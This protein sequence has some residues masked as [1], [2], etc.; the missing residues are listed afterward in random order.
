MRDHHAP[1]LAHRLAVVSLRVVMG[2][3]LLS[4]SLGSPTLRAS[5]PVAGVEPGQVDPTFQTTALDSGDNVSC[6]LVL[7]DGRVV[8]AVNRGS[9]AGSFGRVIRLQPDGALD[10]SFVSPEFSAPEASGV[11]I[12]AL[13]TQGDRLLIAGVFNVVQDSFATFVGRLNPD[14]TWDLTFGTGKPFGPGPSATAFVIRS[15]VVRSD[16]RFYAGGGGATSIAR[17][18]SRGIHDSSFISP[19]GAFGSWGSEVL[20]LD[21]DDS[22]I[23]GGVFT[24]G[25]HPNY[26][27]G[28]ARL[29]PNGA[30]DG[31][32]RPSMSSPSSVFGLALTSDRKILFLSWGT[33][34]GWMARFNP[35]GRVDP[36]FTTPLELNPPPTKIA[37]Q[38]DGRILVASYQP[39]SWQPFSPTY[40]L[41]RLLPD[42]ALDEGFTSTAITD[43]LIE[44]L[45]VQG[46]HRALIAGP[47]EKVG[48]EPRPHLAALYIGEALPLAPSIIEEP[49]DQQITEGENFF[50]HA[51]ASG[52]PQT[53][54]WYHEG[55]PLTDDASASL[56]RL[57]AQRSDA[58]RYELVVSNAL[59]TAHSRTV[60]VRIDPLPAAPNLIVNPS[61]EELNHEYPPRPTDWLW[62]SPIELFSYPKE[63]PRNFLGEQEVLHGT[64]YAILHSYFSP[65]PF[66]SLPPRGAL[67]GRLRSSTAPGTRYE[68]TAWFSRTEASMLPNLGLRVILTNSV[69]ATLDLGTES[70]SNSLA[71]QGF[72][73]SFVPSAAYEGVILVAPRGPEPAD[74]AY[75]N[76][77]YLDN[78]SLR[79]TGPARPVLADLPTRVLAPWERWVVTNRVTETDLTEDALRFFLPSD[80]PAGTGLDPRL[81]LLTWQP[82]PLDSGTTQQIPVAAYYL[83]SPLPPVTNRLT[84]IV[85]EGVLVEAGQGWVRAGGSGRIP[86]TARLLA[87]PDTR[88]TN[89]S[90]VLSLP[91]TDLSNVRLTST[92]PTLAEPVVTDL[93]GRRHRLS[94]QTREGQALTGEVQLGDLTFDAPENAGSGHQPIHVSEIVAVGADGTTIPATLG[95]DGRVG[96]VGRQPLLVAA[97][98]VARRT[99]E[100]YGLPGSRYRIEQATNLA[101]GIE[102]RPVQEVTADSF[103]QVVEGVDASAPAL[104][105]RAVEIP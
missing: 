7:A 71:W 18:T 78:L 80:A 34:Y 13:A 67:L 21:Q 5:P 39:V 46:T 64:N 86:L 16:Q 8:V 47:F 30:L 31:K 35:D 24:Y 50:L 103:P 4:A 52:L 59:G 44:H 14:G 11:G 6:L 101:N 22:L 40:H 79:A 38:A 58:G 54:R 43:D 83:G 82:R 65:R 2:L 53:F 95:L 12:T 26:L 85:Q 90:F 97:G 94:V 62:D 63:V 70:K 72:R 41:L 28:L 55:L 99:L 93:G 81:G 27:H 25:A 60:T 3:G 75:F 37:L 20:L 48:D 91:A 1:D 32:F 56:T 77:V 92:P 74:D 33:S 51:R 98:A 68:M 76:S 88:L 49:A 66:A 45:V 57:R 96:L 87:P 89:L 61:F 19:I 84:V 100:L 15:L 36:S 10:T 17:F 23:V 105:F 104:F 69:G 9:G 73:R 102:W 42:G 29:L